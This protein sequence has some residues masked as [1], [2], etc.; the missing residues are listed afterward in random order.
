MTTCRYVKGRTV[1]ISYDL[2]ESFRSRNPS[3]FSA[4]LISDGY[5]LLSMNGDR[6]YLGKDMLL[7]LNG[8]ESVELLAAYQLQAVSISFSPK[9]INV[10]LDSNIISA[11]D[12][13]ALSQ[14]HRYPEL[15]MFRKRS[16]LYNGLLPI[17]D[18][19][20]KSVRSLFD[21]IIQ[22]IE[23]QPDT[24]WSCRARTNLFILLEMAEHFCA[25]FMKSEN[26]QT[27][28]AANVLD[29]IHLNMYKPIKI[30]TL[31]S[32]FHTNSTTLN[33]KFKDLTGRSVIDY[34]IEERIL[35]AQ[36][37][38]AFS[39]LSVEEISEKY[40]FYDLTYFTKVFKKRVGMPPLT[41]RKTMVQPRKTPVC[42]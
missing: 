30:E 18:A 3:Y 28:L 31:C 6:C 17:N 32:L 34:V 23:E 26:R 41:Y 8:S 21:V 7:F 19:L 39:Q 5:A 14:R 2:K 12:Y 25:E 37:S 20:S 24:K 33:R 38:L 10:N 35:L 4:V 13:P 29:Y 27:G 40:G 36:Q 9:F 16:L 1:P 22:Q 11:P 15:T 42:V